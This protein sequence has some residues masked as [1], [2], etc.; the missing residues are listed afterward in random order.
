[1]SKKTVQSD[2]SFILL[3]GGNDGCSRRNC[4]QTPI[5]TDVA[6]QALQ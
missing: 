3:G 1:M 5:R 2:I 6:R 4:D